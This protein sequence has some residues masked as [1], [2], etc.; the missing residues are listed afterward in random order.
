MNRGQTD[1][2][3]NIMGGTCGGDERHITKVNKLANIR[4]LGRVG[5]VPANQ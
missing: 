1:L 2:G 4:V 3:G 5:L